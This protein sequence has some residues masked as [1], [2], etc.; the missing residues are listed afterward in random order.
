MRGLSPERRARWLTP[1]G[2]QWEMVPALKAMVAFRRHNLL[3]GTKGMGT[4]DVV[5]CRNVLIYFD[6]ARKSRVLEQVAATMAPDG[7][8]FLGSAET[9]IGLTDAFALQPG[10]R[11]LYRPRAALAA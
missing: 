10:S 6:Q 4:F 7:A 1:R 5:L 3:D 11:G 2:G 9:V 8:L